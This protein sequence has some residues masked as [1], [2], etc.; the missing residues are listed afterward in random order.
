VKL[1][2]Q[3]N[4]RV[5]EQLPYAK[6]YIIVRL[7]PP[8]NLI[9]PIGAFKSLND[10]HNEKEHPWLISLVPWISVDNINA[11][12]DVTVVIRRVNPEKSECSTYIVIQ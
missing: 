8:C 2:I 4:L 12:P 7:H 10:C 6:R 3:L 1:L 5:L 9:I 11:V